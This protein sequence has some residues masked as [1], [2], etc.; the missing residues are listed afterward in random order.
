M[1]DLS[2]TLPNQSPS[3]VRSRI[4]WV[5]VVGISIY[6]LVALLA[7]LPYFFSWAGVATALVAVFV[8]NTLGINVFYHRFLTHKGFRCRKWAEYVMALLAVCSFQDTPARWVAVHR[9][10]HEH[11]DDDFDPHSPIRSFLWAHI[12]WILVDSPDLSRYEIYGRY[13][14][15]ILRDPF[16]RRIEKRRVYLGIIYAHWVAFFLAGALA[17]WLIGG[18][19]AQALYTGASALIWGVFVRTVI[20]WHITW[21]V[22]SV[23]HVWGYRN[24][25]TGENSRNNIVVGLLSNGEGWHNNHHADPRSARHGHRWFEIDVTYLTIRALGLAG[26]VWHVVEPR[27][28]ADGGGIAPPPGDPPAMSLSGSG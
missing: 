17:G 26:I 6:H 4:N 8:F 20:G 3:N 13:A 11:S 28:P 14:K 21:A 16:Y 15:D 7:F 18:T 23:T 9:R 24:Y 25:E 10:H 1:T 2:P 27:A 5:N 19:G 22:N 12:G